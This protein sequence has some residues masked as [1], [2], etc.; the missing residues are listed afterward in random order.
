MLTVTA[1]MMVRDGFMRVWTDIVAG[2]SHVHDHFGGTGL[3]ARY[4]VRRV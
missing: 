4:E 3:G 1:V 2:A